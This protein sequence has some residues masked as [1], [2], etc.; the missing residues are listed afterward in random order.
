VAF[1]R[2]VEKEGK[3]L[4]AQIYWLPLDGGEALQLTDMPKGTG[5]PLWSPD[6]RS[7]AFTSTTLAKYFEDK[8]D[9][10]ESDVRVI[11]RTRYRSN[12][13]GYIDPERPSHI[14]VVDVPETLNVPVK[15]RPVTS[16]EF[17]ESD[18]AW[19]PDSS[20]IYFTSDRRKEPEF[21]PRDSDLYVTSALGGGIIK[22][23][24]IDGN[25]SD[26][27]VSPDGHRIAF[28]GELNSGE[29]IPDRSYSQP[30]LF[31][32]ASEP[33]SSPRN[34]TLKF[35]RDIGGGVG[36]DQAPPPA[37]GG[38]ARPFWMPDSRAIVV[39]AAEEG[40]TNL[41]RVAIEQ[42]ESGRIE[43]PTDGNH[44]VYWYNTTQPRTDRKSRC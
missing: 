9:H 31:V 11:T 25:I 27:A 36:G 4:P 26:L 15:A 33:G 32:S 44:D 35:D 10:E 8:K 16:G 17:T 41:R 21:L 2:A 3:P 6:G 24:S 1:L 22:V 38:S 37:S 40:R 7:I 14:W 13:S 19:S 18:L 23:A 12:D 29:G 5:A 34:L 42:P 39:R 28:I 43:A 20:K 30:D